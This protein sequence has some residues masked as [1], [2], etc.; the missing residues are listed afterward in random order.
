MPEFSLDV[1]DLDE[2]GKD[3]AFPVRASWL[4][5]EL[6]GCPGVRPPPPDTA[7]GRLT[8]HAQR[9]GGEYLVRGHVNATVVADCYRCLEDVV[10]PVEAELTALFA[11]APAAKPAAKH[12]AKQPASPRTAEPGRAPAG[13]QAAPS[14]DDAE[15]LA[16]DDLDRETFTGDTLILDGLV[17][18]HVILEVPMQPL[19]REDCPGI[20]IP[21]HIRGPAN[22]GEEEQGGGALRA[23]L[24]RLETKK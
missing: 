11:P 4:A 3:Y 10:C 9:S 13:R 23:A 15:D 17:R 21:E 8:L 22:F 1:N 20:P 5:H 24:S 19:C 6:E 18:E 14:E 12:A 7:D 2:Q 16:A